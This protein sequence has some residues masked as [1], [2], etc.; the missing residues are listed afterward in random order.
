LHYWREFV[1]KSMAISPTLDA[2]HFRDESEGQLL[3]LEQSRVTEMYLLVCSRF[4]MEVRAEFCPQ[5]I[6]FLPWWIFLSLIAKQEGWQAIFD[7]ASNH[8]PMTPKIDY[9]ACFRQMVLRADRADRI[10]RHPL[11]AL[12]LLRS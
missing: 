6:N 1:A 5:R 11:I 12:P 9:E 10:A 7:H 3:T 4:W 8:G 2:A